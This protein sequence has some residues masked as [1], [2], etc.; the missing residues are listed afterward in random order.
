[1]QKMSEMSAPLTHFDVLLVCRVRPSLALLAR[2]GQRA[3]Q[4]E[5]VCSELLELAFHEAIEGERL[6]TE[7]QVKSID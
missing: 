3:V 6:S 1:M 7:I 5:V 2:V 4:V